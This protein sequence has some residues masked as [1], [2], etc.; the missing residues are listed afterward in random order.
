MVHH[1]ALGVPSRFY[2]MHRA[3][4]KRKRMVMSYDSAYYTILGRHQTSATSA[5]G[6][7]SESHFLCGSRYFVTSR[8][9]GV[10]RIWYEC[11]W[12]IHIDEGN[13]SLCLIGASG[14]FCTRER[15]D[16]EPL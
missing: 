6:S 12:K 15:N 10:A 13:R 3:R 5:R 7:S 2:A 11:E 1:G 14:M 9:K 4:V 16:I 8:D